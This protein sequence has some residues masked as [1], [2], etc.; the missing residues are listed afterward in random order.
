[1]FRTKYYFPFG[2]KKETHELMKRGGNGKIS[3][4]FGVVYDCWWLIVCSSASFF[5]RIIHNFAQMS[6]TNSI[7]WLNIEHGLNWMWF[8]FNV[9]YWVW[10]CVEQRINVLEWKCY[11]KF[12]M[13]FLIPRTAILPQDWVSFSF[14]LAN[15]SYLLHRE[16]MNV[17]SSS[18]T[19]NEATTIDIDINDAE[20]KIF[21]FEAIGTAYKNAVK[22]KS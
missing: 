21:N 15:A 11:N 18:L 4:L 7:H 14:S 8:A 17:V 22:K 20:T 1:M 9:Q 6:N 13:I 2:A 16:T 19:M 3:L 12:W 5:I 10:I